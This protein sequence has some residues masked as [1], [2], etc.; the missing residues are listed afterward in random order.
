MIPTQEGV[1]LGQEDKLPVSQCPGGSQR[2]V[3]TRAWSVRAPRPGPV[4]GAL[5]GNR[6]WPI[7]GRLRAG[8]GRVLSSL[9]GRPP[10]AS[11]ELSHTVTRP[12]G[13]QLPA[14]TWSGQVPARIGHG[15]VRALALGFRAPTSHVSF[16]ASAW[17]S[18][19]GSVLPQHLRVREAGTPL[20]V[21]GHCAGSRV[22]ASLPGG[23]AWGRLQTSLGISCLLQEAG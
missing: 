3:T 14:G 6:A 17:S 2:R 7:Q 21:T 20:S 8:P 18:G 4:R 11:P 23:G 12:K 9:S 19:T 10:A 1:S 13:R 15:C 5:T 16:L 22:Q